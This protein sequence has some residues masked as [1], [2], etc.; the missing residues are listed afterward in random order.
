MPINFRN[1]PSNLM[2]VFLDINTPFTSAFSFKLLTD[3]FKPVLGM[4][5]GLKHC[6]PHEGKEKV[7]TSIGLH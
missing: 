2:I 4:K 6:K 1:K 7:E 3:I 5:S